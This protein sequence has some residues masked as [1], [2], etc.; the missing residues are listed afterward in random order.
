VRGPSCARNTVCFTILR[1][2]PRR[3]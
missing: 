3:L 2:R 1:L